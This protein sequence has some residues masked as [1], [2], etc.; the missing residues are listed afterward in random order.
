LKDGQDGKVGRLNKG[1]YGLKQARRAWYLE[2][3]GVMVDKLGFKVCDADHGVF[4]K[5]DAKNNQHIIVAVAT[6]DMDII[7]NMHEAA[8]YFKHDISQ[9]FRIT[10]LK[11]THYLLSLKIKRDKIPALYPSTKALISTQLPHVSTLPP[12]NP[13]TR[14]LIQAPFSQRTNVQK[15]YGNLIACTTF[16]IDQH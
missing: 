7:A 11:E 13:S 1:L 6:D 15:V 9:H 5:H 10:D 12:L 16:H 3:G 4:I 8:R 2:L 14:C